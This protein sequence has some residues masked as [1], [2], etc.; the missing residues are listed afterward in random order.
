[1]TLEE[2]RAALLSGGLA[3]GVAAR[4]DVFAAYLASAPQIIGALAGDTGSPGY[5]AVAESLSARWSQE[6]LQTAADMWRDP[7][8]AGERVVDMLGSELRKVGQ[9]I[10]DGLAEGLHP[11]RIAKNLD[12]VTGLDPARARAHLKEM[13]D[14]KAAGLWTQ[15]IEDRRKKMLLDQRRETI[16]RTEARF[17]VAKATDG[18]ARTR[19][20]RTKAWRSV[21]DDRVSDVCRQN[22]AAGFIPVDKA[23]PAGHMT[24][25]GHPNCRCHLV[26]ASTDK[27]QAAME[28]VMGD[29]RDQT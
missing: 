17:A 25:P 11:D 27:A 22:E 29:I 24:P 12:M 8:R 10:A 5:Q 19:G 13:Q 2:I 26:Y 9:T 6:T 14:L 15:E 20:A 4:L 3:P 7:S 23:F 21:G 28:R 18:E 1:M 16:A